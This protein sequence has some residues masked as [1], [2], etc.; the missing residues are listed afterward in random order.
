MPRARHTRLPIEVPILILAA[1][2]LLATAFHTER[3]VQERI[4]LSSLQSQ[5]ERAVRDGQKV[6]AQLELLAGQTASLARAGNA[7]ATQVVQ[8]MG[9]LGVTLR[10]KP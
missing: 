3:L 9:R 8:A 5:Q 2:F 6:R 4:T 7:N 10:P 1:A